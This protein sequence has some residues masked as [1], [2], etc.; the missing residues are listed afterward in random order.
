MQANSKHIKLNNKVIFFLILMS[1]L[2]FPRSAFGH[3][4]PLPRRLLAPHPL[5]PAHFVCPLLRPM[6]PTFCCSDVLGCVASYWSVAGLTR[7]HCC[8][9]L[10]IAQL[11]R[12]LC[13]PPL[14]MM[15]LALAWA[16]HSGLVHIVTIALS[17]DGQLLCR[18]QKTPFPCLHLPP[19]TLLP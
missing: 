9:H 12:G 15:A 2:Q 19:L 4:D 8:H 16:S 11:G 18:A 10:L 7:N 17:S 14:S 3:I 1:S 5:L 6:K 13:L